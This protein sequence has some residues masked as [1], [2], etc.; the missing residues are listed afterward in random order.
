MSGVE[1]S[2][3]PYVGKLDNGD[4]VLVTVQST[5]AAFTVENE[6]STLTFPSVTVETVESV[7]LAFRPVGARTW[8]PPTMLTR[9]P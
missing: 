8:G 2:Y 7:E 4:E 3:V 6:L 9:A 5:R 1:R